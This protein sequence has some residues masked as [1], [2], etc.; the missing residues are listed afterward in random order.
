MDDAKR[1][2]LSKLLR[3]GLNHYGLG[4]L[5]AA[6]AYWERVCNLDPDNEAARDYLTSAYEE[7]GRPPSGSRSGAGEEGAEPD[8]PESPTVPTKPP[9]KPDDLVVTG[10]ALYRAG[11]LE[12]A[13]TRLERAARL[14]P[15]RL[16]IQGYLELVRGQLLRQYEKQVGDQGRRLRVKLKPAELRQRQLSPEAGYLLSQIDV[17][18]TIDDLLSLSSV[19][20]FETL[21]I[22]SRLLREDIVGS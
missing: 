18:V 15:D 2:E 1:D 17:R 4:E 8:L 5:E 3:R 12:E 13:R 7:M 10:L 21:E 19:G 20:R 16:D 6:I 9:E 22:L 11:R 14:E